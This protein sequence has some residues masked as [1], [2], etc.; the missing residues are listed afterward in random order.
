MQINIMDLVAAQIQASRTYTLNLLAQ[1]PHDLW[2]D[3]PS[4]CPTHIGWQVG[5]LAMAEFRLGIAYFREPTVDDLVV[6]PEEFLACFR[7]GTAPLGDHAFPAP[8]ALLDRLAQVHDHVL[9]TLPSIDPATLNQPTRMKHRI[10]KT[11][12]DI[13]TWIAR[14][15]SLH[16]GQIGLLRRLLGL[17]AVS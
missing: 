10:A 7:A 14:H 13:L 2:Y 1:T 5:H 16:A 8:E 17:K 6:M 11:G 4:G 15:E 3:R 9:A 12:L